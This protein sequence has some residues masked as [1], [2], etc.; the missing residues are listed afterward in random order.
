MA[1]YRA[2]VPV[3]DVVVDTSGS[4]GKSDFETGL[5]EIQGVLRAVGADVQ[6]VA[7]D[8]AIQ[9]TK[10]IR[11]VKDIV[12]SLVGGGGSH[13]EEYF[14]ELK[15]RKSKPNLIVFVTDG[16]ASGVPEA[17]PKDVSMIWLIT[18]AGSAPVSWGEEI[19]IGG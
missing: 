19:K 16:Y 13:F 7:I 1:A 5:S 12:S 6:F 9:A 4:M 2:P 8:A 11:S 17:A 10:R 14:T 18:G 3:V 15:T